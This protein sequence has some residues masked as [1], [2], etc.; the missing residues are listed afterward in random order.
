MILKPEATEIF[1]SQNE[2]E[3]YLRTTKYLEFLVITK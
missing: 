2:P 1:L 3:R